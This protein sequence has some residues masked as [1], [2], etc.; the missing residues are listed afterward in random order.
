MRYCNSDPT[1]ENVQENPPHDHDV[2]SKL[3][4]QHFFKFNSKSRLIN[5]DVLS[6]IKNIISI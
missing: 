5:Y 6:N 2:L 3:Y 4:K 1:H